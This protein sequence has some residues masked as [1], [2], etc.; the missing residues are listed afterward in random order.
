M[1]VP[2]AWL[3]AELNISDAENDWNIYCDMLHAVFVKDFAT[4]PFPQLLGK[5]VFHDKNLSGGKQESFW[6]LTSEGPKTNR[7]TDFDRCRCIGWPRA[8]LDS[9]PSD[10]VLCWKIPNHPRGPR[11]AVSLTD[12][13]YAMFLADKPRAMILLTAF[14]VQREARRRALREEFSRSAHRVCGR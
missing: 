4:P 2:F 10:R 13:S 7:V 6:H 8:M 9:V 12:C 14:P 11:I 5:T 3:P 1:T